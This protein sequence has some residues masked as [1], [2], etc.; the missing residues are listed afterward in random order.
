MTILGTAELQRLALRV[1]E[2][3]EGEASGVEALAASA[4]RAY[5]DLARV[6]TPL[7]GHIGVAAITDR[8]LHLAQREYPWLARTHMP[9]PGET[10]FDHVVTCLTRQ[11]SAVATAAATAVLAIFIG[12][13]VTFIGEPLTTGLLRKAWP[14]AFPDADT[15]GRT[16]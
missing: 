9:A 14:G 12:L 11:D 5:G 7:I 2:P 10:P 3:P 6:S 16:T 1:L 8:A 4:R 13:L 15:R